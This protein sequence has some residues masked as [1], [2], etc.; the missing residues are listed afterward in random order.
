MKTNLQFFVAVILSFLAGQ[1]RAGIIVGPITNPANGHD[2]Y[3][4]T[5]D[6]WNAA[7]AEAES[8][9][10]TLAIIGGVS[11]FGG[12]L[13]PGALIFGAKR[14]CGIFV[15]SRNMFEDLNRFVALN[16]I[17]PAIDR[18]FPFE[19]AREAFAYLDAGLHFGK[20]VIRVG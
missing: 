19:Q 11:G 2:Y 12:G 13:N 8:L 1:L 14:A 4:L 18:I 15:G 20:V 10:G 3:L 16:R 6:T 7:E 5:P 17:R 9:G